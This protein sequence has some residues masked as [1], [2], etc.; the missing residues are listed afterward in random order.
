MQAL[1]RVNN[2]SYTASRQTLYALISAIELDLRELILTHLMGLEVPTLLG[3]SL[4]AK[5]GERRAREVGDVP[6]SLEGFIE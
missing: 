1:E 4:F 6:A 3:E 2:M 5:A